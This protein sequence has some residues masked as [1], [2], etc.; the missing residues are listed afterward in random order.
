MSKTARPGLAG[1]V[2][3]SSDYLGPAGRVAL[4]CPIPP[5]QQQSAV[6][7]KNMRRKALNR[8]VAPGI[9]TPTRQPSQVSSD[10]DVHPTKRMSGNTFHGRSPAFTYTACYRTDLAQKKPLGRSSPAQTEAKLLRG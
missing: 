5:G 8:L 1:A 4:C 7:E 9:A 6:P 10:P 3:P 2:T